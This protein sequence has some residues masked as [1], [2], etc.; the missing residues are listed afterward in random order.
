M[1][2]IDKFLAKI[3]KKDRKK[4]LQTL[5]LIQAN[6]LTSLDLKKLKG[7]EEMYRVR[8]GSYRIIFEIIKSDVVILEIHRRDDHIYD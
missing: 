7:Q 4:I 2:K 3:G 6:E 5:T 8:V 1:H